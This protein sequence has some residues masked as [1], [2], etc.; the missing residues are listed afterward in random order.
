M[1]TYER[2]WGGTTSKYNLV[3]KTDYSLGGGIFFIGA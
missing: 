3:P 1:A 2:I